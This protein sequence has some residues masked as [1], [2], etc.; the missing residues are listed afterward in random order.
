MGA[1]AGPFIVLSAVVSGTI[2]PTGVASFSVGLAELLKKE[3]TF[4]LLAIR[5]NNTLLLPLLGEQPNSNKF[6][7]QARYEIETKEGDFSF[8]KIEQMMFYLG[9][10]L[11]AKD[12][13]Y[14]GGITS[15]YYKK[16]V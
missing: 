7:A 12:Y 10:R 1:A 5:G 13:I 15:E 2:G 14:P 3:K 16:P 6:P 4:K 9:S 8:D 11:Y